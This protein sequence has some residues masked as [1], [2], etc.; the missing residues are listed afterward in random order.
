MG[1]ISEINF[2]ELA[3]YNGE[4]AGLMLEG[5]ILPLINIDNYIIKD[6]AVNYF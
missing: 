4:I 2:N 5:Y 1:E 3:L 6:N